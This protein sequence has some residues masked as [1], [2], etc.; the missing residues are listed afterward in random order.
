MKITKR[1][2]RRII[3]EARDKDNMFGDNREEQWRLIDQLVGTTLR[4]DLE[5]AEALRELADEL[6]DRHHDEGAVLGF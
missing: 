3:K 2:L 6:E 5:R 4:S 1:Q